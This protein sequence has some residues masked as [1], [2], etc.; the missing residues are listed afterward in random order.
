MTCLSISQL[1]DMLSSSSG[2]HTFHYGPAFGH[3]QHFGH[4]ADYFPSIHEE[5]Y[6]APPQHEHHEEEEYK[7]SSFPSYKGK[8]DLSIRDFFE[9]ALTALA[10]LAFGLF[11]IQLC[12][13]ATVIKIISLELKI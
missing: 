10:F 3:Q 6:Y 1:D 2:H 7:Y 4:H 8:S 11:V 9:I 12:M 13:N 5:Y